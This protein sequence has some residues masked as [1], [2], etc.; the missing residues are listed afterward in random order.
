M[1]EHRERASLLREHFFADKLFPNERQY[2]SKL[3]PPPAPHDSLAS[4]IA[5]SL[6]KHTHQQ[7]AAAT[8]SPPQN[9]EQPE[10][11]SES[12]DSA[13]FVSEDDDPATTRAATDLSRLRSS[14]SVKR[15]RSGLVK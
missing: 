15:Y 10:A 12:S 7:G 11:P 6:Q 8:S 1:K 2:S 3:Y 5:T 13:A 9:E 14:K 4:S